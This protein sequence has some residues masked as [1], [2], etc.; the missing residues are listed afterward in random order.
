M[1][2]DIGKPSRAHIDK[3]PQRKICGF[4]HFKKLKELGEKSILIAALAEYQ[5]VQQGP[6]TETGFQQ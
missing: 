3:K 4:L 1:R 5:E 6:L 2:Y